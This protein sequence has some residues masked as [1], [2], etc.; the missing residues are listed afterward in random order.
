[1]V[2]LYGTRGTRR[3]IPR[4][5]WDQRALCPTSNWPAPDLILLLARFLAAALAS[6]CFFHPL[7]LAGLQVEGVTFHFLDDV[8]LLYLPLKPAKCIFEG[9]TLL[10][11][12]FSQ[13]TDTPL[14][15]HNWTP[16]V[17]ASWPRPSQAECKEF[18]GGL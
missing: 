12:D 16:L 1:M 14:L 11:S 7:L 4:E 15:V 6:E 10:K 9:F 17:M 18:S 3:K 5:V 8:F 13:T 2:L